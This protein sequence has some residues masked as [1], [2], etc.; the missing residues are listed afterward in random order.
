[1]N[2]EKEIV[3]DRRMPLPKE[4]NKLDTFANIGATLTRLEFKIDALTS[5]METMIKLEHQVLEQSKDIEC[6]YQTINDLRKEKEAIALQL[7]ALQKD[8]EAQSKS[9]SNYERI[10][11]AAGTV[12]AVLVG[13]YLFGIG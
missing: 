10:L 6:I 13:K 7:K 8:F 9:I 11:W 4:C 12:I 1:M 2:T 5:R 3:V